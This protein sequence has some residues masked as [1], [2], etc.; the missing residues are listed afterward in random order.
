MAPT[1]QEERLPSSL[2]APPLLR[3]LWPLIYILSPIIPLLFFL[4]GNWYSFL[5]GWSMGILFGTMGY[6][7]LLNQ[8]ITGIRLKYFD[9]LYGLDRVLR[10]HV[11][12][13]IIAL[14]CVAAHHLIFKRLDYLENRLQITLGG[15]A[16]GIFVFISVVALLLFAGPLVRFRPIRRLRR[17]VQKRLH[18]QYQHLLAIHNLVAVAMLLALIHALLASVTQESLA[19]SI[20]LAGWYLVATILYLRHK[21]I[22][23][24]RHRAT[25][26]RVIKVVEES[27][28]YCSVYLKP[29]GATPF[30]YLPGQFGFVR[31]V[32]GKQSREEH[33]YTLSSAPHSPH[34]CF[35]AQKVGDW[36]A[37]L[38]QQV[39]MGDKVALDGPYGRFSHKIVP[40]NAPLIFIASGAGI[41]PFMSML[42]TLIHEQEQRSIHLIWQ[43]S[44]GEGQLLADLLKSS[45][46]LPAFRYQQYLVSRST[47]KSERSIIDNQ[48][49]TEEIK[50]G[51]FF[52]CGNP[53]FYRRI[54]KE[55]RQRRVHVSAIHLEK[56]EF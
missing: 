52:I 32:S 39:A 35:T 1:P 54:V 24:R 47:A 9:R 17:V 30:S 28:D 25:P 8:F 56:F 10:F 53:A 46:A 13:A 37:R 43:Q 40:P 41:T 48:L 45:A 19:R 44:G 51:R 55:L 11:V 12:M 49:T 2:N 34:I 5:D 29:P 27:P 15:M 50:K 7:Y 21:I 38:T 6:I 22:L 4:A 36:S 16:L 18:I 33:P 31:F 26:Y 23:P 3:L 20:I 14:I 42:Q